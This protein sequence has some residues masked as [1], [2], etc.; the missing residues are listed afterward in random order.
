[1]DEW[2]D[3]SANERHRDYSRRSN[4][5]GLCSSQILTELWKNK[6]TLEYMM[7]MRN[8]KTKHCN[9][10]DPQR[11]LPCHSE[12]RQR[13]SWTEKANIFH[14]D[15]ARYYFV[16]QSKENP[17]IFSQPLYSLYLLDDIVRSCVHPQSVIFLLAFFYPFI[18]SYDVYTFTWHELKSSGE[19]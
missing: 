1:M 19:C 10:K 3:F 2:T 6:D 11:N 7:H 17:P 12:E 8:R 15:L 16:V 18:I 14:K 9:M 5:T 13:K 4:A